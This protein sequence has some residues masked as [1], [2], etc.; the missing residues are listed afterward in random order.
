[1]SPRAPRLRRV[2]QPRRSPERS[3]RQGLPPWWATDP[4]VPPEKLDPYS[5]TSSARHHGRTLS[6]KGVRSHV[7]IARAIASGN[8]DQAA[9]TTE[10][11]LAYVEDLARRSPISV[12]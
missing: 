7:E 8:A 2:E 5:I 11:L 1:M 6:R 4:A 3:G 9:K 12:R 10:R